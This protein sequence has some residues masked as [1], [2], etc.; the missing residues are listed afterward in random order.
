MVYF[1]SRHEALLFLILYLIPLAVL[2]LA[3]L[4][5][6][7]K[8][9]SIVLYAITLTYVSLIYYWTFGK[10]FFGIN[11]TESKS[12]LELLYVYPS[13]FESIHSSDIKEITIDRSYKGSYQMI[14]KTK[15][16]DVFFGAL[17]NKYDVERKIKYIKENLQY[18]S[19]E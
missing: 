1:D 19:G 7:K 5:L 13:R 18:S 12:S 10:Y 3:I 4:K 11:I 14:V 16:G 17:S 15:S 2:W 6:G 9:N 8:K